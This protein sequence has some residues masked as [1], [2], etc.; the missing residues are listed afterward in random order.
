MDVLLALEGVHDPH[1]LS[2]I[3]RTADATGIPRIIW[4]PE[5]ENPEP[6]NHEIAMGTERWVAMEI[7]S[8]L[9]Q[10]LIALKKEGFAIAATHLGKTSVDFRS[11]DWTRPWI[12]VLGNEHRGCTEGVLEITDT[13]VTLPMLGFVQSLN[14]SVAGAVLMYEIQRQREIAGFFSRTQPPEIVH[15]LFVAWKLEMQG[16]SEADLLALP[17]SLPIDDPTPHK[18]GR[19]R[20]KR[21]KKAPARD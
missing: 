1:N 17:G 10:R 13:N 7:V 18:D 12:V 6:P 19:Q 5:S 16:I 20:G 2:A 11:V 21:P 3:L 14:V 15:N 9:K 4:Q 8:D